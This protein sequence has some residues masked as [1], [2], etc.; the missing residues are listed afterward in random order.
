MKKILSIL[1]LAII[2]SLPTTAK[3][4][5]IIL[6]PTVDGTI[7]DFGDDGIVNFINTDEAIQA[8]D[9]TGFDSRGILEFD[10]AGVN[11]PSNAFLRL[12]KVA[13][14]GAFPMTI[15]VYGYP[16]D[17]ALSD[18]DYNA[19]AFLTS[20]NYNDEDVFDLDLTP[21]LQDA[22]ANA[23]SFL[24]VNLRMHDEYQGN[25]PPPYVAWGS[26]E[27]EFPPPSELHLTEET[28]PV[29]PEPASLLLLGSGFIGILSRR[30]FFTA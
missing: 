28:G 16:A 10:L 24:G 23:Y 13:S 14:L 29:V 2:F 11:D 15:D 18:A 5:A 8:L 9:M 4:H 17:G 6:Y 3:A 30:K 1:A 26:L 22:V 12:Y 7:F 27:D 20:S 21:H 25:P 19:G